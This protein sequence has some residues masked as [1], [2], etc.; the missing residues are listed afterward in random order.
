MH[1][2]RFLQNTFIL[3]VKYRGHTWKRT[4]PLCLKLHVPGT[5]YFFW[6]SCDFHIRHNYNECKTMH[7]TRIL[8]ISLLLLVNYMAHSW[9]RTKMQCCE[10]AY[11]RNTAVFCAM[12]VIFTFVLIVTN[13]SHCT[14]PASCKTPLY[15]LWNIQHTIDTEVNCRVL[16]V[17]VPGIHQFFWE[18]SDLHIR[19]N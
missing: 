6:E 18:T 19:P 11:S 3:L 14:K 10:R 2:T 16:K 9:N 13:G 12:Q 17:H 8:Q 5:H 1:K 4:K 7:T 15:F